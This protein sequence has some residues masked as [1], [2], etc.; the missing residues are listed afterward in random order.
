MKEVHMG[1]SQNKYPYVDTNQFDVSFTLGYISKNDVFVY[2]TGELDSE[3]DQIFRDY[4]WVT[5]TR[6]NV[7]GTLEVGDEVVL[8]RIVSKQ[9]LVADFK[10]GTLDREALQNSFSQTMMALHEIADGIIGDNVEIFETPAEITAA[11]EFITNNA[12][13]IIAVGAL[14]ETAL[15]DIADALAAADVDVAAAAASAAAAATS[16]AS[17]SAASATA[18][19]AVLDAEQ[20]VTDATTQAAAA[21]TSA[22][23]ADQSATDAAASAAEAA[24]T[25]TGEELSLGDNRTDPSLNTLTINTTGRIDDGDLDYGLTIKA[26]QPGITLVDAS[27]GAGQ[28]QINGNGAGLVF[29][30]DSVNN[31]GTIGGPTNTDTLPSASFQSN[32]QRFFAGGSE[33]VKF[34]AT[35]AYVFG[36]QIATTDA[37]K[38][39]SVL[40]RTGQ[41]ITS[42]ISAD[43]DVQRLDFGTV[44]SGTYLLTPNIKVR[45][46]IFPFEPAADDGL[47]VRM[48]VYENEVLVHE[49]TGLNND[50]FVFYVKGGADYIYNKAVLLTLTGSGDVKVRFTFEKSGDNWVVEDGILRLEEL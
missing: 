4:E 5:D 24:A 38:F 1:Y 17:A 49:E 39:N 25:V 16:A 37:I 42:S 21:A 26:V 3:G 48:D 43:T 32:Q 9:Q 41:P 36:N 50:A 15:T 23:E 14:D 8:Q 10:D 7:L 11:L 30:H 22:S 28:S 33:V 13:T 19:S 35:G 2:V 6:I 40:T 47:T 45:G 46:N 27:S 34:D 12:E 31:D 44:A 20:A 29:Y 18:N